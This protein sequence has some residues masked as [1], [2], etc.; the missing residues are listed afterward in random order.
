MAVLPILHVGHPNL[1]LRAREVSP[2]ELR[3]EELQR[4]IDAGSPRRRSIDHCGSAPSR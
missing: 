4:F 1:R 2:E 3:T